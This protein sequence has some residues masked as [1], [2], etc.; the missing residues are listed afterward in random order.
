MVLSTKGT[1]GLDIF[2]ESIE[3]YQPIDDDP[4]RAAFLDTLV[5]VDKSEEQVL[6]SMGFEDVGDE[7]DGK[8]YKHFYDKRINSRNRI[9]ISKY[10]DEKNSD[11][12]KYTAHVSLSDDEDEIV[13]SRESK[14]VMISK[15]SDLNNLKMFIKEV[16]NEFKG[17]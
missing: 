15:G 9:S 11:S 5:P 14:P 4:D 16:V 8:D 2:L 17:R 6:N 13:L 10:K 7:D 3:K 1:R 12:F